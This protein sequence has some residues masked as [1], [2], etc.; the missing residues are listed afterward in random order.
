MAQQPPTLQGTSEWA[1][2]AASLGQLAGVYGA[3]FPLSEGTNARRMN[4]REVQQAAEAVADAADRFRKEVDAA[5]KNDKAVD[6][7]TRDRTLREIEMLK[8]SARALGARLGSGQP[9]SGHA[10]ALLDAVE[11]VSASSERRGLTPSAQ[12]AWTSIRSALETVTTSFDLPLPA[13]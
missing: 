2:L 10:T 9:A 8:S 7:A 4:D 6:K 13:R 11:T 3:A 5:L 12:T 1:R